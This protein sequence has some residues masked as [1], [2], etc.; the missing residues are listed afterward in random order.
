MASNGMPTQ[1]SGSVDAHLPRSKRPFRIRIPDLA[2]STSPKGEPSTIKKDASAGQNLAQTQP[3]TSKK[4]EESERENQRRVRYDAGHHRV[5]DMIDRMRDRRRRFV[6]QLWLV[7]VTLTVVSAVFL[8]WQMVQQTPDPTVVQD[9]ESMTR[10]IEPAAPK[11]SVVNSPKGSTRLRAKVHANQSPMS[12]HESDVE[13]AHFTTNR[14]NRELNK[15]NTVWLDG[16]IQAVEGE[17]E[18]R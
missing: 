17:S 1:M 12:A 6:N 16:S 15:S 5:A 18:R 3:A 11:R 10:E 9:L 14:E 4:F 2:L 13:S 8:I 7:S